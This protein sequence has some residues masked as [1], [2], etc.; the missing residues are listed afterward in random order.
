VINLM[1]WPFFV[2]VEPSQ[3]VRVVVSAVNANSSVSSDLVY[4]SGGF[5]I[6]SAI[7]SAANS[8]E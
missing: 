8:I 5:I 7:C 3:P 6:N 2:S 4:A 1:R